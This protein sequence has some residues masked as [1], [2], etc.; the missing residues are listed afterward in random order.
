MAITKT[1]AFNQWKPRYLALDLHLKK[2]DTHSADGVEN[3]D[4]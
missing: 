3:E 1:N 4:Q 2:R